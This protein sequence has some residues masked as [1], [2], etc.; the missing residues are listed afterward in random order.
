[1]KVFYSASQNG[2]YDDNQALPADAVEIAESL[3]TELITAQ[4]AGGVIRPGS[5]G[6]PVIIPSADYVPEVTEEEQR[7]FAESKKQSL[8]SEATNRIGPLQY[9][10]DAG[11]ATEEEAAALIAWQDYRLDLMRVDTSKPVWPTPPGEQA[12]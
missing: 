4:N 5:Y 3:R 7:W 8:L 2:F 10:V 6:M 9:A 12:S 11:K 1:M